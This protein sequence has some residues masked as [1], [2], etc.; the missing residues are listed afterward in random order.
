MPKRRNYS[1]EFKREAVALANQPGVTK[2]QIGRELDID[3]NM[4]TRWQRESRQLVILHSDRGC[5]FTSDQY[6]RFQKGHNLTCSVSGVVSC[7]DNAACKGFLGMLKR[8]GV[9]RRRY[10][11]HADSRADIFD[12]I[13][14]FYN[15]RRRRKMDA[16]KLKESNLT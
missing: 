2:A 13:E 16:L 8:E 7:A 6:Q 15:P 1:S 14:C 9:N 4:I 5:Q 12:Y 3:P 10:D 11:S